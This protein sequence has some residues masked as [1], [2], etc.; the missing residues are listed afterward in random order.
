MTRLGHIEMFDVAA[1]GYP[2]VNGGLTSQRV[3]NGPAAL[4]FLFL[5]P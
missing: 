1:V 4:N 5:P 3:A 2:Y